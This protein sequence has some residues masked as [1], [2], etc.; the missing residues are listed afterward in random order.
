MWT[1]PAVDLSQGSRGRRMRLGS[2]AGGLAMA[3][4]N[5]KTMLFYLALLPNLVPLTTISTVTFAELSLLLAVVYSAVL[6]AYMASIAYARR[7]IASPRTLRYANRGS[8]VVMTGAAAM[9]VARS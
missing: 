1:A 3:V 9:V 5:P 4:S 7:L 6:A 2:I 8:A